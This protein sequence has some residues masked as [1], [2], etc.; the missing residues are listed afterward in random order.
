MRLV[1]ASITI[2]DPASVFRSCFERRRFRYRIGARA[3]WAKRNDPP[4]SSVRNADH[5]G[6]GFSPS[7]AADCR[8]WLPAVPEIAKLSCARSAHRG[9]HFPLPDD[10]PPTAV[11]PRAAP[12][13]CPLLVRADAVWLIRRRNAVAGRRLGQVSRTGSP[14]KLAYSSFENQPAGLYQGFFWN[15]G[16]GFC[17]AVVRNNLTP[18]SGH[19]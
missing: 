16:F 2:E 4:G 1:G 3:L 19:V 18:R 5:A 9:H 7:F 10:W 17:T 15:G 12:A 8:C 11:N 13:P 6:A 14:L